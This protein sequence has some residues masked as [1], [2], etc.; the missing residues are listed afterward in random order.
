[1]AVIVIT[2][3]KSFPQGVF[4]KAIK[5]IVPKADNI[6]EVIEALPNS[7]SQLIYPVGSLLFTG[8]LLQ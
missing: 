1:M 4:W 7:K 3:E 8:L 5:A 2:A 6:A